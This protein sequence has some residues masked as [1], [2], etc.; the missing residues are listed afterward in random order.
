MEGSAG[1]GG[2]AGLHREQHSLSDLEAVKKS[3]HEET[4]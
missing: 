1:R 4:I 3:A 2:Q